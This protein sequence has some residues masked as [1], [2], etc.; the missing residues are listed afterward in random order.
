MKHVDGIWGG[1][2]V[3]VTTERPGRPVSLEVKEDAMVRKLCVMEKTAQGW[4]GSRCGT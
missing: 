1:R 3:C 2:L 4:Q